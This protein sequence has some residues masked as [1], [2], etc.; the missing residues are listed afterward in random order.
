MDMQLPP[1]DE[2]RFQSVTTQS[3]P[4]AD[5][6]VFEYQGDTYRITLPRA[7]TVVKSDDLGNSLSTAQYA[8]LGT[9]TLER[10]ESQGWTSIEFAMP[11]SASDEAD[12]MFVWTSRVDNLLAAQRA[13]GRDTEDEDDED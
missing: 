13:E 2:C 6:A 4:T 3:E 11:E 9:W 10:Q 5:V 1:L 8:D 12:L 7:L